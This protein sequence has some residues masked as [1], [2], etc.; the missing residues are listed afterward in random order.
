LSVKA[1][2]IIVCVGVM[3]SLTGLTYASNSQHPKRLKPTEYVQW[4]E[5]VESGLQSMVSEGDFDFIATFRPKDYMILK[6]NRDNQMTKKDF[7]T[8]QDEL[9][10]VQYYSFFIALNNG[11]NNV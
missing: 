7:K 1:Y 5:S 4:V 9:H 10:N 11:K 3:V 6:E 2:V 8:R